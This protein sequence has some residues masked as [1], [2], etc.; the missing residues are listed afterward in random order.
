[1]L[2]TT[3]IVNLTSVQEPLEQ[4]PSHKYELALV[5]KTIHV[6]PV[7]NVHEEAKDRKLLSHATWEE[8]SLF[9]V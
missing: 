6:Y 7:Q 2:Q 8:Y 4:L 5:K 1:M 3:E 9:L